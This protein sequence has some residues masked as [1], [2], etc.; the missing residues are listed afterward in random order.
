MIA[1]LFNKKKLD[2]RN[3]YHSHDIQKL[4][5]IL[6]QKCIITYRSLIIL[7]YIYIEFQNVNYFDQVAK[8]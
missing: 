5:K 2:S 4:M 3:T 1:Q 8:I 6:I 7:Y